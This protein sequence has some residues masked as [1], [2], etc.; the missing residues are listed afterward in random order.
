MLVPE[1]GDVG[2]GASRRRERGGAR[3][4]GEANF[5]E[6]A[7][8]AP[9]D[10]GIEMPGEHV[11]IEHVPGAALAHHGADPRLGGEQALGN[12]RLD[13]LAQHRPRH[14]EHRDEFGIAGQPRP[15]SA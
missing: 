12:Q 14:A 11:G 5:G 13:A 6:I 1:F 9:V 2:L 8:K 7:E 4:D 15:P 10:A 3:L